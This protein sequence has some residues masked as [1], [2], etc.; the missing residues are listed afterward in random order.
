MENDV[1]TINIKKEI[2]SAGGVVELAFDAAIRFGE[3]VA[4]FG[5]SGVGKTSLLRMLSGLDKPDS[6][7]IMFGNEVWFDSNRKINL[8]PRHRRIGYMFQDYALFPNMTVEQNIRY[9]QPVPDITKV[10][11]LLHSFGLAELANRKPAKLSGGQKQRVALARALACE[12]RLLLLDE[13]LSALDSEMR[14]A[15]QE[16]IQNAHQRS[17]ATTVLV[18]HDLAEVFRLAN[19]VVC[20]EKGKITAV[21]KP[22]QLFSNNNISG[23]VQI[24]GQIVNIQPHDTFYLLTVVTGINQVIRVVAF[25]NDIIHLQ[26]GDRVM[27]FTK[28]FNPMI[29]K[30]N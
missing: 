5:P 29:I 14:I 20:I 28:A 9:A 21:G 25:E 23:K 7:R 13:P 4:L 26:T 18:S 12:P 6:G 10:T 16:E 8:P 11:A 1:I 17:K 24:T 2:H 27:V 15:L 30:M 22:D 19:T 3:L